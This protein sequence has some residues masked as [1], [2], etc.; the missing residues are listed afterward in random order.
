VEPQNTA[1][2]SAVGT[3]GVEMRKPATCILWMGPSACTWS[4]FSCVQSRGSEN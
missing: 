3:K 2:F 4:I 1:Q